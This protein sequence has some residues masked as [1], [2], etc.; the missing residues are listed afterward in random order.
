[1][2]VTSPSAII[3]HDSRFRYAT[4]WMSCP[5]VRRPAIASWPPMYRTESTATP[6]TKAIA[7]QMSPFTFARSTAPS[8][9]WR[10]TVANDPISASSCENAFTTRMPEKFS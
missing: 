9:Y 10:F 6:R 3:G 7:G 4:N 5:I 8:R 2:F 1:M